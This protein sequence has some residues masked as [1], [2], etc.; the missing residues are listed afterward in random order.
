MSDIIIFVD[1]L[2]PEAPDY[3]TGHICRAISNIVAEKGKPI[4]TIEISGEEP[5]LSESLP[6]IKKTIEEKVD[7][8]RETIIGICVDLV[9]DREKDDLKRVRSGVVLLEQIKQDPE[10]KVYDVLV[11]TSRYPEIQEQELIQ[12][13]AVC[14]IRREDIRKRDRTTV[15]DLMAERILKALRFQ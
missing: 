13:G 9:D 4:R 3:V 5:L 12:K 1:D 15:F 11:Y 14:L 7:L 6:L 10:I 2:S 8:L